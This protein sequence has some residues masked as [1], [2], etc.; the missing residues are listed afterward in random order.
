MTAW[1]FPVA[2][3]K[4]QQRKTHRQQNMSGSPDAKQAAPKSVAS[5]KGKLGTVPMG[6]PGGT[7]PPKFVG[8]AGSL[9]NIKAGM[10]VPVGGP[11]AAQLKASAAGEDAGASPTKNAEAQMRRRVRGPSLKRRPSKKQRVYYAQSTDG[12]EEGFKVGRANIDAAELKREIVEKV[13]PEGNVE[14]YHLVAV[15]DEGVRRPIL[16]GDISSLKP[17]ERLTLRKRHYSEVDHGEP[18]PVGDAKEHDDKMRRVAE[19]FFKETD[20]GAEE[21]EESVDYTEEEIRENRAA[22]QEQMLQ[23]LDHP[24]LNQEDPEETMTGNTTVAGGEE[25]SNSNLQKLVE[26]VRSEMGNE[27]QAPP[28]TSDALTPAGDSGVPVFTPSAETLAEVA[29]LEKQTHERSQTD[30]VNKKLLGMAM[31]SIP[32]SRLDAINA[33]LQTAE[34]GDQDDPWREDEREQGSGEN[35][36]DSAA[37]SHENASVLEARTEEYAAAAGILSAVMGEAA[38]AAS[39]VQ[40]GDVAGSHDDWVMV[41][42]TESIVS[43]TSTKS[44]VEPGCSSASVSVESNVLALLGAEYDMAQGLMAALDGD[45]GRAAAVEPVPKGQVQRKEGDAKM[46][47]ERKAKEEAERKANEEA[48]AKE[49]AKEAAEIQAEMEANSVA[50]AKED[51]EEEEAAESSKA[52]EDS[53]RKEADAEALKKMLTE[54]PAPRIPAEKN[55]KG[56]SWFSNKMGVDCTIL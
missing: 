38:L 12:I 1:P 31:F 36:T 19:I 49:E 30:D 32:Q 29:A 35:K 43:A 37:G 23:I 54:A 33:T 2:W 27:A 28:S 4:Q 41:S 51:A 34:E 6:M 52:D 5:L 16:D 7:K 40:A 10:A 24:L 46:A 15:N 45:A 53:A 42:K 3:C 21:T 14:D 17:N 26:E 50:A 47:A 18:V 55:P 25:M 48:K 11:S 22:I 9:A 39:A 44:K 20:V 56:A 13:D 8:S